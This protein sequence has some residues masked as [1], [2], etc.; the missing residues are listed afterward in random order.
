[1]KVEGANARFV[2]EGAFLP[3]LLLPCSRLGSCKVDQI[4]QR[5]TSQHDLALASW[6][7]HELRRPGRAILLAHGLDRLRGNI[8]STHARVRRTEKETRRTT[9]NTQ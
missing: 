4:L 2:D 6:N 8:A 3:S 7:T 5:S 9:M 1:M